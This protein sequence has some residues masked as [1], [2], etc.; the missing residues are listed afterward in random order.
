MP[1]TVQPHIQLSNDIAVDKVLLPGD[2][3]RVDRLK[4][5]LDSPKELV[6]NRE[7]KSLIG[8]YNGTRVLVMSTGMGGPSTG[9]GVEELA[10]IGVKYA[11]R[12]GSCGALQPEM[13]LGDLLVATG[14]IRDEGTTKAYMEEI[15]P[16]VPDFQLLA[17]IKQALNTKH[18]EIASYLDFLLFCTVILLSCHHG[19][20]ALVRGLLSCPPH[21][22]SQYAHYMSANAFRLGGAFGTFTL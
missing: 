13:Q 7:Y 20:P 12:I 21:A 22:T 16:A 8:Y 10:N 18:V 2:P 1:K 9:I 19:I 15:Y 17:C 6:F 11:I 5:W 14:A 3:A 4:K